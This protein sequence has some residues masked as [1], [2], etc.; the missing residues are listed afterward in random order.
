MEAKSV[1]SLTLRSPA[2]SMVR[3]SSGAHA[4]LGRID[5]CEATTHL[6][7]VERACEPVGPSSAL[8]RRWSRSE[9]RD[10]AVTLAVD[11]VGTHG[12]IEIRRRL[13]S[14]RSELSARATLVHAC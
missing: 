1:L 6:S 11:V 5:L 14:P 10:H 12:G 3:G 4:R 2:A 13:R 9:S 8:T 7:R